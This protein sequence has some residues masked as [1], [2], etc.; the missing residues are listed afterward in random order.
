MPRPSPHA[1]DKTLKAF[2]KAVRVTR[3]DQGYSQE[4]FA[5]KCEI[6]RAYMGAIERGQ[7]NIGLLHLVKIAKALKVKV[8]DIMTAARL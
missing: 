1:N 4:D 6:D 5:R 8:A 3:K 2:G 7:A